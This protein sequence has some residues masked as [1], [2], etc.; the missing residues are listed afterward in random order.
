MFFSRFFFKVFFQVF[1]P[2]VFLVE[3]GGSSF[4]PKRQYCHVGRGD[5]R[6]DIENRQ[7]D[8]GGLFNRHMVD[9]RNRQI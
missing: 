9:F 6:G 2:Q 5:G 8:S 3:H 4:D 1:V 7:W